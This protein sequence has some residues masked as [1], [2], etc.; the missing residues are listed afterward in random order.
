MTRKGQ[1]DWMKVE[2]AYSQDAGLIARDLVRMPIKTTKYP[3]SDPSQKRIERVVYNDK[4]KPIEVWEGDGPGGR[5]VKKIG[6]DSVGRVIEQ[7]S[8][9]PLGDN[10]VS[11]QYAETL[12]GL[13]ITTTSGG[14]SSIAELAK[15]TGQVRKQTDINGGVT[16]IE[17]DDYGRPTKTTYPDGSAETTQYSAD[18][19]T[20]TMT[21]GGKTVTK[22]IDGLG[23]TLWVNNPSGEEDMSYEYY[24]GPAVSKVTV[25]QLTGETMTGTVK[26]QYIYDTKLRKTAVTTEMGTVTYVYD[27]ANRKVRVIDPKGRYTETTSDELGQKVST[28]RSAD[29]TT[30]R[31]SYNLF[32][33]L[34][35]TTDP[36]GLIRK[37]DV[38]TYGR[39]VQ[40]YYP[41]STAGNLT[42]QTI[43]G[44]VPNFPDVVDTTTIKARDGQIFRTYQY[45]YDTEGRITQTKL[46]GAVQETT[47]YDETTVQNGKGKPTTAENADASTTADFDKLGR[48]TE[49]R[50]TVKKNNLNKVV[51]VGYTYNAINGNVS[52][53]KYGDGK[54]VNVDYD[55]VT[56]RMTGMKYETKPVVSYTY[57]PNGTIATMGYGNGLTA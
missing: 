56:Q 14:K 46:N 40:R 38:D 12:N 34:T 44:Y 43:P 6:Y 3:V 39:L 27:D 8:P 21:R 9:S 48:V 25:G 57:N 13:T 53:I 55:P 35:Q 2:T 19:K 4:G 33:E 23:R 41:G 10:V 1:T 7:R 30:V 31:Y 16:A 28:Y 26:K 24:F 29:N 5:W 32:G 45:V 11:T 49:T 22:K 52:Q 51:K 50:V 47:K 36:R 18:L 37:T 17:V 15:S 42:V 54:S 20:T